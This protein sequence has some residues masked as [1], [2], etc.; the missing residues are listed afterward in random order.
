MCAKG[1]LFFSTRTGQRE[2]IA[3]QMYSAGTQYARATN[4]RIE[5]GVESLIDCAVWL[6]RQDVAFRRGHEDN[7]FPRFLASAETLSDLMNEPYGNFNALIIMRVHAGDTRLRDH[8]ELS[9]GH[10]IYAGWASQNE[11]ISI[12]GNQIQRQ[13]LVEARAS[14]FFGLGR[15]EHR[16]ERARPVGVSTALHRTCRNDTRKSCGNSERVR[17]H[18]WYVIY[19]IRS[20]AFQ[21]Q[22]L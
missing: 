5:F 8:L 7:R 2:T 12:T 6:G 20:K 1:T 21:T 18:N 22:R 16:P 11:Y 13:I 15:L 9:P 14:P 17:L 19:E 10:E 4:E 3:D